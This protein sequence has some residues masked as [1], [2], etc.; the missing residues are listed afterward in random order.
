M[1][2]LLHTTALHVLAKSRKNEYL[3]H[4]NSAQTDQE[5]EEREE[6]EIDNKPHPLL[7]LIARFVTK[8]VVVCREGTA[9]NGHKQQIEAKKA[10]MLL[11]NVCVCVRVCGCLWVS[12]GVTDNVA[13]TGLRRRHSSVLSAVCSVCQR[14][15]QL[16][17]DDISSYL[18]VHHWSESIG[19]WMDGWMGGWMDGWMGGWMDG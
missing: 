7:L 9:M 3:F 18:L 6:E 4:L 10:K 15:F 16:A 5:E 1:D 19:L 12:M 17:V 13:G 2:Y 14:C 8:A 11:V